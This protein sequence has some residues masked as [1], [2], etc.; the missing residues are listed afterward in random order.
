MRIEY[1]GLAEINGS[2]IALDDV[3]GVSYDELA[4]ITLRDGSRRHGCLLYTSVPQRA[5]RR[6]RLQPKLQNWQMKE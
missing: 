3:S 6:P 4:E 5:T 1:T 2:L